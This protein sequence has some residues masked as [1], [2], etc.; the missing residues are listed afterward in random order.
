[1]QRVAIARALVNN[2]DILLADE[3]TGALDSETSIQIMDLLKEVAKD[4]LVVMVTHNPDL[5]YEYANRIVRV[6]D[7]R[8]V[9]DSNPFD[10]VLPE[11]LT[12]KHK[13]MG[14]ASMSFGTA[15][16]LSFNNLKTKLARTLLTAFAGSIGIIGIALILSLSTGFQLYIDKIQEDTLSNYPL[17][18]QAE[19]ADMASMMAAMGT[20][21]SAGQDADDG[22]VVEQPMISEMF[23]QIGTNDLEAFKAYLEENYQQVSHAIRDVQYG[24]GVKPLIFSGDPDKIFQVNPGILFNQLFG[25]GTMSMY[26]STDAFREMSGNMDML[27]S[28]YDV[29]RGRWPE[30]YDELVLVLSNPSQISDFIAYTIG[31]K[32]PNEINSMIAELMQGNELPKNTES[33]KWT[34][35]D[36]MAL[37]FKLVSAPDLYQYN[38]TYNVWEDMSED[39][40]Y[41]RGLIDNGVTLKIVGIVVP[42]PGVSATALPEGI[43]YTY[44]L[45][46]YVIGEAEKPPS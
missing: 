14:R 22:V 44:R 2:P 19:T 36:L 11:Q 37:E 9:D 25:G 41:M 42:K 18:I 16:S 32:D 31:L 40:D 7:G 26:M 1:M 34:Y 30:S 20:V 33:K 24:Y 27:D 13:N 3:P 23:A 38:A 35:D 5:A 17:T 21:V 45:T 15:L 43:A 8:I 4:R 28:Q 12:P 10:Y 39:A 6:K 29:I 46:Q